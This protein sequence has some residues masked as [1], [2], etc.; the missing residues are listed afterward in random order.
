MEIAAETI[1]S[2]FKLNTLFLTYTRTKIS[3]VGIKWS[4]QLMNTLYLLVKWGEIA[5]NRTFYILLYHL[6]LWQGL[7]IRKCDSHHI[8]IDLKNSTY[9]W[10]TTYRHKSTFFNSARS[11][12][13]GANHENLLFLKVSVPEKDFVLTLHSF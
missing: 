2:H 10:N 9:A 11:I 6:H 13:D 12:N 4:I 3:Q 8:F 7:R 5:S 1:F